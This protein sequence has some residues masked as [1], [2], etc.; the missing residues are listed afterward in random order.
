[1][2]G[3]DRPD[4][5]MQDL[6]GSPF[7]VLV[8]RETA[9]S[10]QIEGANMMSVRVYNY[11]LLG[12]HIVR[13]TPIE[14][15][16]QFS[17][18][19]QSLA[20]THRN[21]VL[22]EDD[23]LAQKYLSASLNA[24]KKIRVWIDDVFDRSKKDGDQ[25]FT[26]S[27]VTTLHDAVKAF[28]TLLRKELD[29]A[30]IFCILTQGNLSTI[31]LLEGAS[32]GYSALVKPILSKRCREEID[33]SGMCLALLRPTASALHLM[34]AIEL[35][36]KDYVLAATGSLPP[37]NRCNWGEYISVLKTSG[38]SKQITDLL[39]IVKDNYRNPLMHPEDTLDVDEA[40]SLF[41]LGQSVIEALY[42]DML[43]R[44]LIS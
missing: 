10:V 18:M 40:I 15:G 26:E 36:V 21:L 11:F 33:E 19:L 3:S 41:G 29:E 35:V 4:Q 34:R 32:Q 20:D 2:G 9:F 22:F 14:N 12:Q 28:N 39:Q 31:K 7:L 6:H 17:V 42:R 43:N 44:A 8:A 16:L 23:P 24:G 25:C 30:P 37:P 38:A 27:D 13:T 1:M 5:R